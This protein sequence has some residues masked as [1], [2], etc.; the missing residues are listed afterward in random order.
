METKRACL[1]PGV[2]HILEKLALHPCFS[3][4][5]CP[6]SRTSLCN[7]LTKVVR[8]SVNVNKLTKVAQVCVIE[9]AK[10]DNCGYNVN[11]AYDG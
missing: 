7:I 6:K 1:Q 5:A 8:I 9:S 4:M 10:M 3:G 11:E 2:R